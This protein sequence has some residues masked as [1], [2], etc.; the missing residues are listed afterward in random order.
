[1]AAGCRRR[2]RPCSLDLRRSLALPGEGALLEGFQ[3]ALLPAE[4]THSSSS[5]SVSIA[6]TKRDAM[7][8]LWLSVPKHFSLK[9]EALVLCCAHP[10]KGTEEQ[11][12]PS[13]GFKVRCLNG[14]CVSSHPTERPDRGQAFQEHLCVP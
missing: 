4:T 3:Q 10:G 8:Q 13:L 14:S 9:I 6:P 7:E 12:E 5:T 2:Q 11:A 1:M